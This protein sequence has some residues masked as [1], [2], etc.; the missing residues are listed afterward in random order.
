MP[1]MFGSRVSLSGRLAVPA[2]LAALVC[3]ASVPPAW[4]DHLGLAWES[5]LRNADGTPLRD[6]AGY[7]VYY[8]TASTAAVSPPCNRSYVDVADPPSHHMAGLTRGVRYYF[9]ITARD[10]G[11]QESECSNQITAVPGPGVPVHRGQWQADRT[12]P[13]AL[14]GKA[15]SGTVAFEATVRDSD[16]AQPIRLQVEVKRLGMPFTGTVSCQSGLTTS[17]RQA[18]CAVS[19]LAGGEGYHWRVRTADTLGG[20]SAWVSFATNPEAVA[21]FTVNRVPAVP[22]SRGQRREDGITPLPLGGTATSGTVVF[23]GTVSDPDA[24]QTVRLQ[25]EVKRVGTAFTGAVSCQSGLVASG[26]AT[27]CSV[28]GLA[29]GTGY[30]WRLRSVDSQGRAGAWSSFSTNQERAPDFSIAG[31]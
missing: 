3:L 20:T 19:G 27:R 31:P 1:V 24:R 26:T 25:V 7:R 16:A 22:T 2:L 6:L 12:T 14:G 13:I 21:D 30:H 5:P 17:G 10:S 8:G 4:A 29:P 18:R 23:L 28:S 9:R 11:G 15:A